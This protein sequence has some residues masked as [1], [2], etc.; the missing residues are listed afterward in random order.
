MINLIKVLKVI[1]F[2]LAPED[3][4]M[5]DDLKREVEAKRLVIDK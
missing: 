2:R 5:D 1:S 4:H 3:L